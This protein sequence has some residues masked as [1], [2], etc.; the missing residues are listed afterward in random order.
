MFDVEYPGINQRRW[1]R[2]GAHAGVLFLH[3]GV[4]LELFELLDF[5]V[6]FTGLDLSQD[7]VAGDQPPEGDSAAESGSRANPRGLPERGL[8]QD[9][10]GGPPAAPPT[11]VMSR[12]SYRK[13]GARAR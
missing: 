2:V 6:G 10:G 8:L 3:L 5:L 1:G 11:P 12:G 13:S 4:N 7:D 9:R